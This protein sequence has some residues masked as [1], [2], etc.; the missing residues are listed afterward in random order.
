MSSVKRISFKKTGTILLAVVA[1]LVFSLMT[2]GVGRSSDRDIVK[3][4]ATTNGFTDDKAFVILRAD[5]LRGSTSTTFAR[6]ITGDDG[7]RYV[8]SISYSQYQKLAAIPD[9]SSD[10]FDFDKRRISFVALNE[11]TSASDVSSILDTS[12][13]ANPKLTCRQSKTDNGV[14]FVPAAPSISFM[15]M[16]LS[17]AT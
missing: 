7:D 10:S 16:R 17:S 3:A 9:A 11:Q 6:G 4:A 12:S 8:C 1:L 5:L 15:N 14:F 13:K 2:L